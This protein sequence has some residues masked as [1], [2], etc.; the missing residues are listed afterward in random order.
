MKLK[1]KFMKFKELKLKSAAELKKILE[2]SR[3]KLRDLRF[4][5]ANRKLKDTSE[6][7]K[8]KILAARILT[9]LNKL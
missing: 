5:L 9:L 2:E 6:I 4:K 3:E 7:E 8:T 1:A